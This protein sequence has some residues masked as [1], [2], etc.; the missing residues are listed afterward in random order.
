MLDKVIN[1]ILLVVIVSLQYFFIQGM[2][3]LPKSDAEF[4]FVVIAMPVL[5]LLHPESIVKYITANALW[6]FGTCLVATNGTSSIA[7][8]IMM[9]GAAVLERMTTQRS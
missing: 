4:S 2:I 9:V 8:A 3:R 7:G 1:I 6:T 5:T